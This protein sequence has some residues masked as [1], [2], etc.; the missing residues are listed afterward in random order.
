MTQVLIEITLILVL[1]L[2]NGVFA[3]TEIAIVSARRGRLKVLADAGNAQAANVL[4]LADNPNRFL[5]TV[6]IGITL[7]GIV[8]GAFGGA[9]LSA[10]LAEVLA[11]VPLLGA[12][13]STVAFG[14]VI[15]VI[16]YF[17]LII[18]ELL[19]K[20][21]GLLQPEN[22]AMFMAQPMMWI[23]SIASPLVRFLG[24]STNVLLRI[25]R[26]KEHADRAVSE[27]DVTV[28]IREG[29][30]SGVFHRAE[31]EMIEGVFSLDK[32]DVYELMTP[33]PKILWLNKS[34]SHDAIWRKIAGS[35]HS[36]FPVYEG[37]RDNLIGVISIKS[38]YVQLAAG[39]PIHLPELI[40]PPLLVPEQQ[41]A[42]KLLESFKQTGIHVA[43][44]VNE[45][46]SIVGMVTLIDL[47][48]AIVGE[49]PL[50]E[51]RAS[52]EVKRREDGSWLVDAMIEIWRVAE[53][54]PEFK[55][56]SEAGEEYQTLAGFLTFSL[57]RIPKEGDIVDHGS[58]RL[59]IMDMDGHRVDKVLIHPAVQRPGGAQNE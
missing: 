7:V 6:Q 31:S 21:L 8:A 2:A 12:H 27:E 32:L 29:I 34:D 57:Q 36:Y 49:L 33:R 13:A 45:F 42:T 19:P 3:M 17:S 50:P 11:P 47:L 43:F 23:S 59:E 37:N 58:L 4:N 30:V 44:V 40:V 53:H 51:Q 26:L 16:T 46:G 35:P 54:V 18:G 10:R 9:T 39:A 25:M 15:A 38:L 1:L 41:K 22:T 5:S 20:R 14:L 48:E 56:P 55:L 52:P 24:W 28:L